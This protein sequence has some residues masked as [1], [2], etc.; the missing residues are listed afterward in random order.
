MEAPERSRARVRP[1]FCL[2]DN[3]FPKERME[4]LVNVS[5]SKIK[6]ALEKCRAVSD[7]G[8]LAVKPPTRGPTSPA[9]QK[10]E[11][12]RPQTEDFHKL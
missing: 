3:T 1:G 5:T 10:M 7:S 12:N 9:A 6:M 11:A 4:W 2:A 8:T